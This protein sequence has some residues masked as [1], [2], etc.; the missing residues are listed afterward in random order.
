M[1]GSRKANK[2]RSYIYSRASG[3][4]DHSYSSS[5]SNTGN[6]YYYSLAGRLLGKSDGTNTIF[7]LVDALGTL[8]ASF[9]NTAN[10][11]ALKGNQ[12]YGPYGKQ[13][14]HQGT[15][16]TPKG[17]TG[18]YNDSLTGLDYYNA[19]YYDP[20]AGVFLSADMVQGNAQG[21]NSLINQREWQRKPI[22]GRRYSCLK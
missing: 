20:V 1:K 6:T 10:S 7:Y 14:Y 15:I 12:V 22:I 19:R 16:G 13:R 8:Q 17:F 4:E 11:A 2:S 9:S 3:L 18:Q 5:G 21:M